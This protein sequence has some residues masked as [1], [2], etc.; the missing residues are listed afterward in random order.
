MA[1]STYN[2]LKNAKTSQRVEVKGEMLVKMQ[3]LLLSVLKD[4][5]KVCDK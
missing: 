5:S 4:F 1:L 3:K 2:L